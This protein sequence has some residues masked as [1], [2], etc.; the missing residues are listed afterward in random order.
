MSDI[1]VDRS[2]MSAYK[3]VY[4]PSVVALLLDF[5][6]YYTWKMKTAHQS[7]HIKK[8]DVTAA[9]TRSILRTPQNKRYPPSPV[10]QVESPAT[11]YSLQKTLQMLDCK[12]KLFSNRWVYLAL[13]NF[14]MCNGVFVWVS[15]WASTC[16]CVFVCVCLHDCI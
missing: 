7:P 3:G 2:V 11:T 8:Q 6:L 1:T 10:G 12:K 14:C 13:C 16:V 5:S 15:D 4:L 9:R